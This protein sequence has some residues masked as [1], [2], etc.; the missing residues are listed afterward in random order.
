M[1]AEEMIAQL[2][3]KLNQKRFE[4]TMGVA[5]EARRLAPLFGVDEE[6]A[7][8]AGLLHDCAKN[9]SAAEEAAYCEKYGVELDKYATEEHAL[10]HAFLGATVARE[11]YGVEDSEILDAIYYHTTGKAD[12]TPLEKLIYIAD[13]TEPG[14]SIPQLAELRQMVE[15]DIDKALVFAIGC[16][17]NHVVKKGKLIHPN[18][19]FARNYLIESR[20]KKNDR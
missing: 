11:D 9:F 3:E 17:I 14:R 4:H 6:K 20:R 7:Y 18:S 19:V 10:V 15:E 8:I 2:K 5:G 12:M 13:M 1:T 16:S